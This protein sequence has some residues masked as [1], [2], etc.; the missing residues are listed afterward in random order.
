MGLFGFSRK[1]KPKVITRINVEDH[2][3][4]SFIYRYRLT[5]EDFSEY[6]M[7]VSGDNIEADKKK[8]R[9][10]GLI[11]LAGAAAFAVMTYINWADSY[12]R[13]TYIVA[14]VLLLILGFYT[15]TFYKLFFERKLEKS[16]RDYYD[17]SVY[18]QNYITQA[19]YEDGMLEKAAPRDAF[20]TWDKFQRA[21]NSE[22]LFY[23]EFN[24]ANQLILPIREITAAGH[25]L[26]EML[27]FCNTRIEAA[28]KAAALAEKGED[29]KAEPEQLPEAEAEKE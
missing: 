10:W 25:T 28:K 21:W 27:S 9:M 23:L 3:E 1:K 13:Q 20:F 22:N 18:L 2:G 14:T 6:N 15:I 19:F 26:Y 8:K 17:N 24:L 7:A 12:A 16:S 11:E 5:L 29:A 4:P